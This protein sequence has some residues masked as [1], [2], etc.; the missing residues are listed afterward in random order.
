MQ[1]SIKLV[2]GDTDVCDQLVICSLFCQEDKVNLG[3][4]KQWRPAI[5]TSM[6]RNISKNAVQTC[7]W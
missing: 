2:V 6:V 5:A 7:A 1:T 4:T 3:L